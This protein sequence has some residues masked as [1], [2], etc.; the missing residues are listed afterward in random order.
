MKKLAI[1]APC[2]LPVPA[3]KGG[4]VEE[5]ITCIINQ[6]EISKYFAIDLFTIADISYESCSFNFTKIFPIS[7]GKGFA[8]ADK[9]L[10]KCY[11]TAGTSHGTKRSFDKKIIT[12]FMNHYKSMNEDYYA[13]IVENQMSLAIELLNV[14]GERRAFPVY[15]HMHNDVDIYRSPYYINQLAKAGVQFIA[16]SQYIKSQILKY[17]KNAVVHVLYNGVDLKSYVKTNRHADEYIK[18]LYAGRII[19]EKG[20]LELVN[21]FNLLLKNSPSSISEKVTLDIIGFSGKTTKYENKIKKAVGSNASKIKLVSRLSTKDMAAKYNEYDVVVMPTINEEPFGLVALETIA[22]GIPLITTNSGALPEVVGDG[23]VIVDKNTNFILNLY[24]AM[25]DLVHNPLK[26]ERIGIKGYKWAKNTLEFNIDT[27]YDRLVRF[28]DNHE[29]LEQISVIVPVFNV[30][31]QL[32]RCV[33]S[34]INQSYQALEI[35]LIDDGS[36]DS[37]GRLCDELASK[38]KRI[39][40]IHQSNKGLSGARNSGLDAMSGDYVF[41]IDSDDYITTDAIEKLYYQIKRHNADVMACGISYVWDGDTPEK[42]FT[43]N[44]TGAWSGHES[45]IRMMRT[46]S[47]CT[48]A[49]NKLYKASLWNNVR[50]PEGRLHED[51]ATTYKVLY[52]SKL[53]AYMP[54][55]LYKYYQRPGSLMNAGLNG[56]Y[57]DYIKAIRERIDY[58]NDKKEHDLVDYSLITLLDYIKYVYRISDSDTKVELTREFREILKGYGIPKILGIKKQIALLLW[59]YYKF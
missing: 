30:E 20:V 39:K 22:K 15:F 23:A 14:L 42:P 54:N 13:V 50:F 36:T 33:D 8:L 52:K 31:D 43:S 16:I 29:K 26:R 7:L 2:I 9:C 28:V 59:N 17:E 19:A 1:L 21:A 49:W 25:L 18:F 41:F 34:L 38:D 40:V 55:C 24:T 27:Y 3:S 35:I 11:R 44:E 6:N 5:L 45:V 57:K 53:V 4:A 32:I 48:V 10:D 12:D 58:F 46:N 51:E 56:R 47:I 37:S